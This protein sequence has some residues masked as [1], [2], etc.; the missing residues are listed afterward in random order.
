MNANPGR[1]T[2][3]VVEWYRPSQ[4][5]AIVRVVLLASTLVTV[6]G[7]TLSLSLRATAGEP[8]LA[9]VAAVLGGL[10]VL[11]GPLVATLGL[12]R[13]LVDDEYLLLRSDG[14]VLVRGRAQTFVAWSDLS[15]A[16]PAAEVGGV[17]LQRTVGPPLIVRGP[18]DDLDPA[19]L[20]RRLNHVRRK[21]LMNLLRP[22]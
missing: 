21:A 10:A 16:M 1:P 9:A 20:A 7:L 8:S 18:F 11:A 19:T 3:F 5:R 2:P 15:G 17:A 13:I 14:V 12:M 4:R 6:G 22:A